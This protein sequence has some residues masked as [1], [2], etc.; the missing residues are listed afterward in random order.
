MY[1][2]KRDGDV[3]AE[4]EQPIVYSTN[5]KAW[6][7]VFPDSFCWYLDPEQ[8]WTVEEAATVTDGGPSVVG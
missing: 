2:L 4:S 8:S 7:V 1:V 5:D 6:G 3:V